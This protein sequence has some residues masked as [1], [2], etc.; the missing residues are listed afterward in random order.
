MSNYLIDRIDI[1]DDNDTI[2]LIPARPLLHVGYH[3][4][5]S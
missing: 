1:D 5:E 2:I 4:V 3:H